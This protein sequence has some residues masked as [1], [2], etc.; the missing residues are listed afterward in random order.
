MNFEFSGDLVL[1]VVMIALLVV[2]YLATRLEKAIPPETEASVRETLHDVIADVIHGA[3]EQ[4]RIYAGR[5][6][7][8]IDDAFVELVASRIKAEGDII[9]DVPE[10]PDDVPIVDDSTT[11]SG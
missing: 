2:A 6:E 11:I 7:N 1:V 4:A 9:G 8:K 10:L 5:T 3:I